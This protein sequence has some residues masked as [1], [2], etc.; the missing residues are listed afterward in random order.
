MAS[1]GTILVLRN[2]DHYHPDSSFSC[3]SGGECTAVS[4][5]AGSGLRVRVNV[6]VRVRVIT[7]ERGVTAAALTSLK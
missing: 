4:T 5:A 6:R 7:M 2:A 3:G 1:L